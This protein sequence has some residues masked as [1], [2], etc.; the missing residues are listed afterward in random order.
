LILR[1]HRV[2]DSAVDLHGLNVPVA[3]FRAQMDHL[4]ESYEVVRLDELLRPSVNPHS[5][6][7]RIALTFDDG[8]E[9][10]FSHIVPVLSAHRFPASFFVPSS[11]LIDSA[12]ELYWWDF[13]EQLFATKRA[14]PQSFAYRWRDQPFTFATITDEERAR[15]HRQ[16]LHHLTHAG[17]AERRDLVRRLR[18][19]S[20]VETAV[21]PSY[22]RLSVDACREILQSPLFEIGAHGVHH[23]ALADQSDEEAW[24]ELFESKCQLEKIFARPIQGFAYPHGSYRERCARWA[25]YAG[26]SYAVTCDTGPLTAQTSA[27]KLPRHE[28]TSTITHFPDWLKARVQITQR[29][30]HIVSEESLI[31]GPG[32][33][34]QARDSL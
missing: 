1:Y 26:Y 8:Y 9:D 32:D 14:L 17:L 27:F 3:A 12:K 28:V 4:A 22:Q 30:S 24:R 5:A 15:F 23:L 11:T 25:K 19:W 31:R 29:E 20:G 21:L 33:L 34:S 18:E 6:R 2:V 10:I 7:P 16:L 13:L